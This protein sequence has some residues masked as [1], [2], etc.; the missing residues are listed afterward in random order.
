MISSASLRTRESS[1][2][3][4]RLHVRAISDRHLTP[5]EPK[6]ETG[7]QHRSDE[8]QDVDSSAR[9]HRKHEAEHDERHDAAHHD[10][11][12]DSCLAVEDVLKQIRI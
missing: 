2:R 7:D 4:H 6:G 1:M 5:D 12:V 8:D 9:V 3:D 11:H 10:R